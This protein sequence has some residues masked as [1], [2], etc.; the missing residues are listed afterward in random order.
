MDEVAQK[1]MDLKE[2]Y[3]PET[4]TAPITGT[5]KGFTISLALPT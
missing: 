3:G 5:G 4:P 1:L 2:K